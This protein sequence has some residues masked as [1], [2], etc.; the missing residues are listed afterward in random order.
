MNEKSNSLPKK[1]SFAYNENIYIPSHLKI[2]PTLFSILKFVAERQR[3]VV[4][5]HSFESHPY[6]YLTV[7]FLP[8]ILKRDPT[9]KDE[10][11]TPKA[12][13]DA[14][15][16][17]LDV[18]T[19]GKIKYG[20]LYPI[21]V[22]DGKKI[23]VKIAIIAPQIEHET[24]IAPY[25]KNCFEFSKK[26]I[27]LILD[28]QF[29]FNF[30]F[31]QKHPTLVKKIENGKI[32][33]LPKMLS[34]ESQLNY[35]I[36]KAFLPYSPIFMEDFISDFINYG[37]S[38]NRLLEVLPDYHIVEDEVQINEKEELL[39]EPNIYFHFFSI[40][41]SL[42]QVILEDLFTIVQ[43][44]NY[45]LSTTSIQTHKEEFS[46]MYSSNPESEIPR[47]DSLKTIVE[48]LPEKNEVS[49]SEEKF[50]E[51]LKYAVQVLKSLENFLPLI[52][53]RKEQKYLELYVENICSKVET[54]C[55]EKKTLFV[56]DIPTVLNSAGVSSEKQ[57]KL[58]KLL[59]MTVMDRFPYLEAKTLDNKLF[60]Y[61]GYYPNLSAIVFNLEKLSFYNESYQKQYEIAKSMLEKA[62]VY[63][64]PDLDIE[65]S[66]KQKL[67]LEKE[68]AKLDNLKEQKRKKLEFEEKYNL[69]AG[70]LG[71]L[72]S[73]SYFFVLYF[74]FKHVQLLYSALPISLLTSYLLARA[75]SK[76]GFKE[77]P[78]VEI[79]KEEEISLSSEDLEKVESIVLKKEYK[80]IE[81]RIFD[82]NSF[83]E[84]IINNLDKLKPI[85]KTWSEELDVE[86]LVSKIETALMSSMAI[87]SIP[88]ELQ[89]P[90]KPACIL[91]F[92]EDLKNST[93]RGKLAEYYHYRRSAVRNSDTQTF[94]YYNYLYDA[95]DR[96]YYK[97]LRSSGSYEM[98]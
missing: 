13:D 71:L 15:N 49:A 48:L 1:V 40:L 96:D 41:K 37:K 45:Y 3:N 54:H 85:S 95:V 35:L 18:Y 97:F 19:G 73:I 47:L 9:L 77:K 89:L 34:I 21:F 69:K 84:A 81:E 20:Y 38:T 61:L 79:K 68:K 98:T 46:S 66:E 39:K 26:V 75:F 12:V 87:V 64:H 62:Q 92:K 80:S 91:F 32:I 56:L 28:N 83:R 88:K 67:Q 65:L 72:F 29:S 8:E 36:E 31:E 51:S 22:L 86:N 55:K 60:Y 93:T 44:L 33:F 2:T 82:R 59:R 6:Y 76:R 4:S 11:R 78:K 24:P 63:F 52:K 16:Q 58:Q 14:L 57:M 7:D 53:D 74:F 42:E 50:I 27:D 5:L 70:I 10:E 25:R 90:N 17:M 30:N 23:I 94:G 43:R